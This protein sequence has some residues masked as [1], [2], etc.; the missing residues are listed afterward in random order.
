M[1]QDKASTASSSSQTETSPFIP[2]N[3]SDTVQRNAGSSKPPVIPRAKLFALSRF[4]STMGS[5][6][7]SSSSDKA[8]FPPSSWDLSNFNAPNAGSGAS[9]WSNDVEKYKKELERWKR[10]MKAPVSTAEVQKESAAIGGQGSTSALAKGKMKDSASSVDDVGEEGSPNEPSV[11][12]PQTLA[13]KIKSLIDEKFSFGATTPTRR[14]SQ[15]APTTPNPDSSAPSSSVFSEIDGKLAQYLSSDAIMNGAVGKG[16][17]RGRESIWTMLDKL[18]YGGKDK[19]K[20]KAPEQV[21][22]PE[23]EG[24]MICTPLQPEGNLDLEIAESDIVSEYR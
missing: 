6:F 17:E 14:S 4:K 8:S 19:G 7:R 5:N 13:M 2:V 20:G 1:T 15:S 12:E 22:E 3:G 9:E 21:P 11:P 16:F 10:D 18:G 23:E 24:I